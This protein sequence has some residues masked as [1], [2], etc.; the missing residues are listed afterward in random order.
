MYSFSKPQ[1]VCKIGDILVG[2]QPGDNPPLLISSMFHN[3]DRILESR[4][5]RK[6]DRAKATEYVKRQEELSEQTGIPVLVAMVATS[7]DEMKTY[8]DFLLLSV[9]SL[10]V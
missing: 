7:V 8:I 3:G 10:L 1:K 4:K 5:E 9:I 2:G 6:F